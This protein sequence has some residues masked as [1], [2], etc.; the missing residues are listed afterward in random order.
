MDAPNFLIGCAMISEEHALQ[1]GV[2][3]KAKEFVEKGSGVYAKTQYSGSLRLAGI[4]LK[5]GADLDYVAQEHFEPFWIDLSCAAVHDVL[6]LLNG[7][8]HSCQN[9][10]R[11]N[12]FWKQ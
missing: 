5:S 7:F 10:C 3:G 1:V 4:F 2:E 9:I 12:L 11:Q 6:P 8:A